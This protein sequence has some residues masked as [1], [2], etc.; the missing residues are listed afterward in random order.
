[1][2]GILVQSFVRFPGFPPFDVSN[3]GRPL[4]VFERLCSLETQSV[5]LALLAIGLFEL[6]VGKQVRLLYCRACHRQH[7]RKAKPTCESRRGQLPGSATMYT[8]SF[9][10]LCLVS[11]GCSREAI[12]IAWLGVDDPFFCCLSIQPQ[13]TRREREKKGHSFASIFGRFF[14]FAFKQASPLQRSA[15]IPQQTLSRK[16]GLY[17]HAM[18]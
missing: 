9:W 12:D 17:C 5:L 4:A 16:N 7:H 13:Q 1:M 3:P 10:R 2:T 14:I 6:T 15:G 11:G 8:G 18:K